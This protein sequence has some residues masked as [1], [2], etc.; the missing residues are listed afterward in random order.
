MTT[1][2]WP[3]AEPPARA[4][5]AAAQEACGAANIVICVIDAAR[6]DHLGCYGYDRPTT[7]EIDRVAAHGTRF[8]HA[9]TDA[10]FTLAAITSLYTGQ[11]YDTH[12]VSTASMRIPTEL[13]TLPEA[14]RAAGMR[15][16]VITGSG[17]IIRGHGLG[18]GVDHFQVILDRD[19][20]QGSVPA[21]RKAWGAWLD[22]NRDERFFL[23]VHIMPPHHPYERAGPFRGRFDRNYR[24]ALPPTSEL[25]LQRDADV[26][27]LSPRDVTHM[28]DMYDE[29]LAYADWAVGRLV[30][31]LRARGLL[32]KTVL[33]LLADHGEAFGE[34]GQFLHGN[35]V[36]NEMTHMPLIL[37]FPAGVKGAAA[38]VD[39]LIQLSDLAPTLGALCGFQMPQEQVQGLD[40]SGVIFGDRANARPAAFSTCLAL[41]RIQHAVEIPGAKGIFNDRGR[42]VQV[43]DLKADP[44]ERRN[45]ITRRPELAQRLSALWRA[46]AERQ[47]YIRGAP[48]AKEG[49]LDPDIREWLR[50]LGYL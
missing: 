10:P 30:D 2:G 41:P 32:D 5:L 15:T 42:L 27:K 23:Y 4:N 44:L 25:L 31:D 7:P 35:T 18:D 16:A 46:W 8:T 36:Y 33:V 17:M 12:G 20:A 24:G 13:V 47:T 14:C 29:A 37:R 39:S 48:P 38:E 28:V 43:F 9:V 26:L 34:H 19:P 22:D 21:L 50:T 11:Y 49:E 45:L 1:N 6:A 40:A 3:E